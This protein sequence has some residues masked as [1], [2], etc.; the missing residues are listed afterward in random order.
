VHGIASQN[1]NFTF[2]AMGI[3]TA[4]LNIVPHLRRFR[5]YI[6]RARLN[7]WQ[8]FVRQFDLG[9]WSLT[10]FVLVTGS[11][12]LAYSYRKSREIGADHEVEPVLHRTQDA[13]FIM[14]GAMTQQG[15]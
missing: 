1:A 4:V 5:V 9:T 15:N 14:Y 8:A 7:F 12:I 2:I 3:V 11:V 6:H 13:F 10:G